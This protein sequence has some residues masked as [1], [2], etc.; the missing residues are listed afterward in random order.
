MRGAGAT[1][2]AA[3]ADQ[4]FIHDLADRARAAA[5]LRAAAETAI[6]L[7]RGARRSR[8]HGAPHLMVAQN[9]AGTDDHRQPSDCE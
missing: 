1:G 6:D 3:G 7:A 4:R 8:L 5:T 9:V 2:W